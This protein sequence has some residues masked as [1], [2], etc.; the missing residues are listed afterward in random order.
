[1]ILEK[2]F[3]LCLCKSVKYILRHNLFAY[4]KTKSISIITQYGA[5]LNNHTI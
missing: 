3:S 5:I 4:V 2:L 1:M